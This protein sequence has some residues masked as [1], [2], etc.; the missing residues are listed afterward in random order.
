MKTR[1]LITAGTLSFLLASLAQLPASLLVKALPANLPLQLQGVGGTLWQGYASRLTVQQLSLNN[2]QWDLRL[3]PL[4]KGHLAA[5]LS[6]Q[7]AAGGAIDGLCSLTLSGALHCNPLSLTDLPA[8]ALTPYVQRLMV[9]PLSGQFQ[10]NNLDLS[11]DR[12]SLPHISGSVEW[13]EAGVQML[14][15][16]YGT[17]TAQLNAGEN[18]SQQISLASAP[19]A[20]F[21]LDGNITLQADGQYQSLINLKPGNSIDDG[22]KQFLSNFIVQPQPDGTYRIQEQGQL[23]PFN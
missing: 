20:A 2:V 14:P 17:Y 16:R 9:P 11:W 4:L 3:L 15:Q 21:A 8:T 22:T 5:Q 6:A 13:Q 12:Q 7:P 1:T 23:P 18:S 19:D 10:A